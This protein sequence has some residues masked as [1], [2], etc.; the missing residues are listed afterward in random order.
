MSVTEARNSPAACEEVTSSPLVTMCSKV[1]CFLRARI[2]CLVFFFSSRGPCTDSYSRE[3]LAFRL[4]R[5]VT[6]EVVNDSL[7]EVAEVSRTMGLNM[8]LVVDV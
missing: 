2:S 5:K 4:L 8:A 7:T 1:E 3:R 6:K